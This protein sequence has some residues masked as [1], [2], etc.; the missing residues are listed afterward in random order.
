MKQMRID[1]SSWAVLFLALVVVGCSKL[2]PVAPADDALL[3]GPVEGLSGEEHAAFLRGDVAFNDDVF[4]PGNGLGP[5]FVATRCA[6]CHA[7]DGRGH[8]FT[9]LTRFGQS[10]NTGNHWLDQGGPQLQHQAV[11]GH[12][13]ETLPAGAPSAR[14]LPPPTTGL[15]FLEV[16]SDEDLLSWADPEDLDG[17]GISGVPNWINMEEYTTPLPGSVESAGRYVGRMGRKGSVYDL[18][19]QTANAYAQDIGINSDLEP[20]DTYTGLQVDPEVSLATINDVVFYLRTLK[21][22]IQ[23]DRDNADVI[24]GES[25][26][27]NVGCAKCH[28]PEMTTGS[29]PIAALTNKA[30]RPFS[31]LLL[32]DM[33]AG[34]DDGYT[35]G[36]ALSSEWRTPPLWGLGLSPNSQGG[37]YFLLHDGRAH[38]IEEAIDMHGG[39]AAASRTAFGALSATDRA[40]LIRFLESL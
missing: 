19:Q 22:P 12:Q 34:L 8:P 20:I 14:L 28:R 40:R 5:V 38:S 10:D 33:G 6:S 16:V 36:N 17:D 30:I 29:S 1:R 31:D 32:H 23:R 13:P 24:A 15:G 4:H 11:P 7:G 2:E 3:D 25:V 39:E 9:A 26:F 37:S 21:A 35:E 18:L 27:V